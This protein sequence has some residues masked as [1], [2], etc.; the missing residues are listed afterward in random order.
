MDTVLSLFYF[1]EGTSK[2]QGC[3]LMLAGEKLKRD[4][5]S[6]KEVGR[7]SNTTLHIKDDD[8]RQLS[9]DVESLDDE[10]MDKN[11]E[12]N[13][14]T[15]TGSVCTKTCLGDLQ[16]AAMEI[17]TFIR[18]GVEKNM[19]ISR[20]SILNLMDYYR[21]D[22]QLTFH[23]I[24]VTFEGENIAEDMDGL[25]REMFTC[26]L[27]A[28]L[29]KYFEGSDAK[30]PK[31]DHD[32]MD[33][34]VFSIIGKIISHAYVLLGYFPMSLCK[35]S[36][37]ALFDPNVDSEMITSPFLKLLPPLERDFMNATLKDP[38]TLK[39]NANRLPCMSIFP[40]GTK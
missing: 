2:V 38:I 27:K 37:C 33:T 9:S 4:Q 39:V 32:V 26:F 6:L 17:K 40:I 18:V 1:V 29:S 24:N 7:T 16:S 34:D 23:R 35:A 15:A 5:L 22:D 14:S 31:V 11:E 12:E 8:D 25:S 20:E 13:E 3:E 19:F 36:L 10:E 28:A 21:S 30:G